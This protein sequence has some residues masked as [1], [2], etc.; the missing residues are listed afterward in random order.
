VSP[1]VF[2][3]ERT[4]LRPESQLPHNLP[5]DG[6]EQAIAARM[7]EPDEDLRVIRKDLDEFITILKQN[8]SGL[9]VKG[10]DVRG[11]IADLEVKYNSVLR[12]AAE[13]DALQEQYLHACADS[14]DAEVKAY[15]DFCRIMDPIAEEDPMHPEAMEWL[16]IKESWKSDLPKEIS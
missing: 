2:G 15:K 6:T 12:A 9:E 11:V 14:A 1:P 13:A 8:K 3:R 10:M 16:E 4:F 5:A 7:F